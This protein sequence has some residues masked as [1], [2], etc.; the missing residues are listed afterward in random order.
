MAIGRK[1][2]ED[3]VNKL[4]E[5]SQNFSEIIK[6]NKE[7]TLIKEPQS[8]N[9]C[10]RFNSTERIEDKI[11]QKLIERGHFLINY[12]TDIDGPFFRLAITR[13]DLT[14]QDFTELTELIIRTG[15]ELC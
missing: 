8:I 7:L 3:R 13:P 10:F 1:G 4:F 2:F 5:L 11:R 14:L 15:H 9:V 6:S 12:S